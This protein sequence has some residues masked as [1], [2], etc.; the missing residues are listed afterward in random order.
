MAKKSE[1]K[2]TFRLDDNHVPEQI[3]WEAEDGNEKG[4]CKATMISIWDSKENNTIKIDLWTKEMMVDEMKKFHHQMLLIMADSFE[5][6]TGELKMANDLRD[7]SKYFAE[8]LG[9]I[10]KKE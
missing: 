7:F 1:I 5:K 10:D 2:F 4:D 3:Q 6:A 8:E 9:L